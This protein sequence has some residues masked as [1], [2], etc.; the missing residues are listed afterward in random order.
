[1]TP[2]APRALRSSLLDPAAR[3]KFALWRRDS[4]LIVWPTLPFQTG[5][6]G[7]GRE[8][9][10]SLSSVVVRRRVGENPPARL[11]LPGG[12][13]SASRGSSAKEAS[14][15]WSGFESWGRQGSCWPS[16]DGGLLAGFGSTGKRI[17]TDLV[18]AWEAEERRGKIAA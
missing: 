17:V 7:S 2:E 11:L 15:V 10:P 1:M 4:R 3:P 6:R 8:G 14:A 16:S 9:A 12:R 18:A 5:K 13:A